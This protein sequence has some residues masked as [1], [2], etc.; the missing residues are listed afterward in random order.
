MGSKN[1]KYGSH[2]CRGSH[3]CQGKYAVKKQPLKG[4][5]SPKSGSAVG[6]CRIVNMD[7]LQKFVAQVSSHSRSCQNGS[8]SLTGECYREGL[9]SVLSAT[10]SSCRMEVAFPTSSKVTGLG[11]GVSGGS[12]TWQPSG[13]R[14]RPVKVMH[15]S[16]RRCRAGGAGDDQEVLRGHREGSWSVMAGVARGEHEGGCRGGKGECHREGVI[17]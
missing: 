14:C 11:G 6:G 16:L 10:C 3:A 15:H 7:Q 9:A 4:G 1:N 5:E 8:I 2:A 12:A 17:P 13:G